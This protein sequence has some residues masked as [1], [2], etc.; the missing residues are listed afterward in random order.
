MRRDLRG[1]ARLLVLPTVALLAIVAFAPGRLPLAIRAYALVACAVALGLG[2]LALRR[3]YPAAAPLGR[4]A[5]RGTD[6]R[7]PPPALARIEDELAL[8]VAG[9]FDLH[10]RLVPRLRAI[11][12]GL[13]SSRHRVSLD[14]D[15]DAARRFLGEDAWDL[16]RPDRPSPDDRRAR[17]VSPQTLGRVVHSLER[18]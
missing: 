16:V 15:P 10:H 14:R 11:A 13:L 1:A 18:V 5:R 12:E 9:A 4:P 17:G 6:R 2:L 8:G 7:K 3:A